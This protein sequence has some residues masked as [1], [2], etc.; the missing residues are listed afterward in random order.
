MKILKSLTGKLLIPV[1]IILFLSSTITSCRVDRIAILKDVP[2]TVSV[3]YYPLSPS[4]SP[5]VQVD[6]ILNIAIQTLDPQ[7]NAMLNQGNLPVNSGAVSSGSTQQAAVS[8]YLVGK[9][10]VIRLP[11]IGTV[12][13]K[14][15]TT[16]K[17]RD[18]IT[19]KISFYFKDP[20]VNVRFANFKVSVLGEV[21]NPSSF[22][23]PNEKPTV[24]DA[25]ALAGDLTIY[26]RRD[27]I[28]LIRESEGRKEITR[29]NLDSTKSIISPYFY[30]RPNDVLYV[31]ASPSKVQSTD[32]YRN[33]N[34]AIIAAALGFL[35]VL[36]ARL[37]FQ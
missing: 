21:G 5:V 36:S 2:D 15:L 11:Y 14:R 30:L 35:T 34:F 4:A 29:L 7:A 31:E 26:G 19:D 27:N 8:G 23:I 18:S 24:F 33:R 13:V 20:V 9:D 12:K 37:L 10:G 25:L 1:T 3:R 16:A 32:A 22:L 17:I 6:D 28:M